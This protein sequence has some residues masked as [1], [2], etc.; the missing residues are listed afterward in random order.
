MKIEI[1]D[2]LNNDVDIKQL[3]S[4]CQPLVDENLVENGGTLKQA[5]LINGNYN[6]SHLA[7]MKVD[8][9]VIGFALIRLS[10]YDQHNTGY[11]NYYYISQL[12]I[13]K[14]LQHHGFGTIL[15]EKIIDNIKDKPLVASVLNTNDASMGLF[16]K[17]MTGFSSHGSYKRFIDNKSYEKLK[18]M[19]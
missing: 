13:S 7:I 5:N 19:N 1:I 4:E 18:V 11:E 3:F 12:V 2:C 8:N 14:K 17:E 15:L 9:V 10:S 6:W 16:S